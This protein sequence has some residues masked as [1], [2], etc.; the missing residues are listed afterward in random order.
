MAGPGGGGDHGP[1]PL[2]V[3]KVLTL[4]LLLGGN[5]PKAP[6]SGQI[7]LFIPCKP[8]GCRKNKP[9]GLHSGE[10]EIDELGQTLPNCL[11]ETK[12]ANVSQ[13]SQK[14]LQCQMSQLIYGW[15]NWFI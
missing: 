15:L 3:H 10:R 9:V 11:R 4:L 7:I 2:R 14:S 12:E 13:D 8:E 1:K 6:H 5:W